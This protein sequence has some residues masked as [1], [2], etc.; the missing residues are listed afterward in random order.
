MNT[1]ARASKILN[2]KILESDLV[3]YYIGC[4]L[5][6]DVEKVYRLKELIKLSYKHHSNLYYLTTAIKI[7]QRSYSPLSYRFS[8]IFLV[9][10]IL[11]SCRSSPE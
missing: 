7:G 9:T 8:L 11:C 3:T 5:N 6:D 10:L 4:D 2:T 1:V